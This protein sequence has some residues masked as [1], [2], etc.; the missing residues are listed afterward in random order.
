M[1]NKKA[2]MKKMLWWFLY[3]LAFLPFGFSI[4]YFSEKNLLLG[5]L[6]FSITMAI[7]TIL[8]IKDL[9]FISSLSF[10]TAIPMLL[11]G[12]L[13]S[14]QTDGTFSS[15]LDEKSF[16]LV[17]SIGLLFI[18]INSIWVSYYNI[19]MIYYTIKFFSR[20]FII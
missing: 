12:G 17:L 16:L 1:K 18:L 8:I 7:Y 14:N 13:A 20:F 11:I 2:L 15:V 19:K 5:L 10:F 9:R 3:L 6:T 4:F